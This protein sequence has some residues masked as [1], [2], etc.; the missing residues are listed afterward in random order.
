MDSRSRSSRRR[1]MRTWYNW[2]SR[3]SRCSGDLRFM[4]LFDDTG[5]LRVNITA[6]YVMTV[7]ALD[8]VVNISCK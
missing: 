8:I 6:D 1:S 4:L 5:L 7:A 3:C 2:C